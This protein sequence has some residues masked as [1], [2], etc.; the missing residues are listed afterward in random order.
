MDPHLWQHARALIAPEKYGVLRFIEE[1]ELI[2]VA[3][4]SIWQLP[5]L[6]ESGRTEV[7]IIPQL[8][9]A[10]T[11]SPGK[12]HQ[13]A[14]ARRRSTVRED[15]HVIMIPARPLRTNE[16]TFCQTDEGKMKG[17]EVFS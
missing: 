11:T 7:L 4:I 8:N 1:Y 13:T 16:L 5:I 10:G 17:G 6:K 12:P 2:I 9:V 15:G 3:D 14:L